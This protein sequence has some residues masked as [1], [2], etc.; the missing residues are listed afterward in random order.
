MSGACE[1]LLRKAAA[2]LSSGNREEKICVL[3]DLGRF[4][5]PAA[6]AVFLRA[7]KDP[8]AE[9]RAVAVGKLVFV[10]DPSLVPDLVSALDDAE[11]KV[12]QHALYALQRLKAKKVADRIAGAMLNDPDPMTRFNAALALAEVGSRTHVRAFVRALNDSSLSVMHT[13]LKALADLA[14]DKAT[15]HIVK[16]VKDRESWERIPESTRDVILRLVEKRLNRKDVRAV[17]RGLV[18]DGIRN[19]TQGGGFSMDV[20]EAARLLAQAGDRTGVP[21]LV[22]CLKGS[23]YMQE[24][25]VRALAALKE[26]SAVPAI[27]EGP[28]RNGFYTI[29]LKAICALGAIGDARAVPALATIFTDRIDDFPVDPSHLVAKDD[30]E[31]RLRALEALRNI[32]AAALRDAT[33]S[34]D[35][36]E[37][38]LAR[39]MRA[40]RA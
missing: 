38:A 1:K 3:H 6:T 5:D 12:R 31:I 7:A 21:V 23:D 35:P 39:R 11:P 37:R 22:Q 8:D 34:Q 32:A 26:R 16:M 14:P 24:L 10:N 4:D 18:A 33:K 13:A 29:K 15:S 40:P 2:V 17:L 28:F 27:I 25:G 30:P 36:F 19:R 20:V 9:V